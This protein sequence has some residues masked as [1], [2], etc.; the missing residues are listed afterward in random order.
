[1]IL[2]GVDVL[3]RRVELYDGA[4]DGVVPESTSNVVHR[5]LQLLQLLPFCF[6][7]EKYVLFGLCCR[8]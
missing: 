1:M 3:E 8:D 6:V 2:F 5:T 7:L 4:I